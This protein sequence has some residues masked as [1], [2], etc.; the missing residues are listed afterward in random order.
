MLFPFLFFSLFSSLFEHKTERKKREDL[1]GISPR[2]ASFSFLQRVDFCILAQVWYGPLTFLLFFPSLLPHVM[3]FVNISDFFVGAFQSP[4]TW[5]HG[6][7]SSSSSSSFSVV[8]L[9]LLSCS[10]CLCHRRRF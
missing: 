3:R 8:V 10:L 6:N 4:L 2:S 1:K 5:C 7:H 9:S